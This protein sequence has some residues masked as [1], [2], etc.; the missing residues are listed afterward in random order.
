MKTTKKMETIIYRNSNKL[1]CEANPPKT[2]TPL[3]G[4]E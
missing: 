2:P 3:G 4:K 1:Q